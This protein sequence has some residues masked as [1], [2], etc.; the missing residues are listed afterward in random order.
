[1]A[2]KAPT[3]LIFQ[4][5]WEAVCPL[6]VGVHTDLCVPCTFLLLWA[7]SVDCSEGTRAPGVRC[8]CISDEEIHLWK[9]TQQKVTLIL[10]KCCLGCV[11]DWKRIIL[12]KVVKEHCYKFTVQQSQTIIL[13]CTNFYLLSLALN[14]PENKYFTRILLVNILNTSLVF[15]FYAYLVNMENNLFSHSCSFWKAL[16]MNAHWLPKWNCR[17]EEIPIGY[18]MAPKCLCS[19]SPVVF[20]PSSG[21]HT[22]SSATAK[23]T[24]GWGFS[25]GESRHTWGIDTS[26]GEGPKNWKLEQLKPF[27]LP[28]CCFQPSDKSCFL[29]LDMCISLEL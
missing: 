11:A 7:I 26:G 2:R 29:C 17:T 10:L 22:T 14:C 8:C 6:Q 9:K 24:P 3:P 5:A 1:M 21:S 15:F 27:K 19:S 13:L 18:W 20:P 28:L 23:A 16:W 4:C 25:A 12:R